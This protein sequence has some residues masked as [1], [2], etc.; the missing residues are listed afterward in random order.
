MKIF[1]KLYMGILVILVASL[2]ISGYLMVNRSLKNS[3]DHEVS[4]L[5]DQ[6]NLFLTSFQTNLIVATK[7]K[8]ADS[9]LV[10]AVAL[11]TKG[12]S[13]VMVEIDMNGA[14]AY[15]DIPE[16][17][18]YG[19]P[20]NDSI[21]YDITNVD[22]RYYIVCYSKFTKRNIEYTCV[23]AT[24][25]TEIIEDNNRQRKGYYMIYIFVILGGTVFAL[26]F[27]IHLTKPIRHLSEAGKAIS[28]GNYGQE[29]E[30]ISNDELGDLTRTFNEMSATIK[31]KLDDMELSVKQ[32]EDFIAAFAHETK[33]PMQSIIGYADLIYQKKLDENES[34]EAAQVI[35]NEGMRLQALSEKLMD[36]VV[37]KESGITKEE[38]NTSEMLE[39]IKATI[40]P[41][42]ETRG[43]EITFAIEDAYVNVDYD[44][45][46]TVIMNIVD[47]CL[48]ADAT[49]I[50]I[51]SKT[52]GGFF[53]IRVKD[54][55]AFYMVDKS[56]SRKEHGA[57]LGLSLVDRVMKLHG[58][59]VDIES[60]EGE[61]TE[62]TLK[63]PLGD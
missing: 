37:L 60:T 26:L 58:G 4:I 24:D 40:S 33:S 19:T 62:I 15:S 59:S 32:K 29:I 52:S 12:N 36:I 23:T 30:V 2:L 1:I 6:Y 51:A 47:N 5:V 27:S 13:D 25:I 41:K 48:K 49:K 10:Q 39:D 44:L 63:I 50:S 17:L 43:A 53:E 22:G 45:F 7:S 57:G 11:L 14:T 8:V 18:N 9:E 54:T 20:A 46:K 3:M 38:I 21:K 28:A 55:D 61:G 56:R 42:A 16:I 35:M 34:R 31:E